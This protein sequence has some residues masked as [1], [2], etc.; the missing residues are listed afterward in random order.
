[1]SWSYQ[2]P[3]IQPVAPFQFVLKGINFPTAPVGTLLPGTI[4]LAGVTPSTISLVATAASGGTPG[5]TYQW[6]RSSTALGPWVNVG[7][8]ALSLNDTGL[9][10][11]TPY[12][13]RIT[14]VDS[15]SNTATSAVFTVTT[16][17]QPILP[18]L[19]AP[20]SRITILTGSTDTVGTPIANACAA[21]KGVQIGLY[22]RFSVAVGVLS[23]A[24]IPAPTVTIMDSQGN[25]LSDFNAVSSIYFDTS[26]LSQV[27]CDLLLNTNDPQIIVGN[28][29]LVRFDVT[30]NC[31]DSSTRHEIAILALDI[32]PVTSIM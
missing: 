7:I 24:S 25:V 21:Y 23:I 26:A 16:S 32:L 10:P 8:G 14:V 22:A 20:L 12:F 19:S 30:L 4:S 2:P 17:P 3:A 28:R 11:A 31:P 1:M 15:A 27:E 29:Y 18:G 6:Q 5:Y 9:T 13:Y